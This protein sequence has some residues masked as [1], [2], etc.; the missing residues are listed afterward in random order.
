[1][2]M[3]HSLVTFLLSLVF[4]MSTTS[5]K[6][7]GPI[8]PNEEFVSTSSYFDDSNRSKTSTL[9]VG[10]AS[11]LSLVESSGLTTIENEKVRIVLNENGSIR[12]YVNKESKL[13]FT[14]DSVDST[15]I[16]V[17]L[18]SQSGLVH[19]SYTKEVISN[20]ADKKE[21]KYTYVFNG[22][23][24]VDTFISLNKNS[25][26]VT[27][28]LKLR[29]CTYK[30]DMSVLDVEYP[31]IQNIRTLEEKQNDIF[32]SPYATGFMFLDPT[33]NFNG[34]K[35][36]GIGKSMGTYP[37]G[38]YYTMQFATYY[39]KNLGGFY[40]ATKDTGDFIKSFTFVGTGDDTCRMSIYHYVD[41]LADEETDFDYDIIISNMKEG[42][43]EEGAKKYRSWA[44]D[45]HW[46]SQGALKNRSD[47]NKDL[48]EN[49]SLSLFGFRS[50]VSTWHDMVTTYDQIT[51]R[52]TNKILNIAIYQ[53][54]NYFDVVREYGH[55][56]SVFEFNSIS[57]LLQFNDNA[58]QNSSLYNTHFDVNGT[59][60][61]YQCPYN[62]EWLQNR[63]DTE[64]GYV[65]TYDV[66]AFYYDVA[67]TAIHPIQCFNDKHNHGT[68]INILPG[69][70]H[71]LDTADK[72]AEA[73][74]FYS[75][76]TEMLHER[77]LPYIDFYQ[78]RANGG[79]LGWMESDEIRRYLEDFTAVKIPMFDYVYHEYGAV[80]MDGYLVPDDQLGD[81]YYYIAAY[82]ALNGGICEYNYEYFWPLSSLPS[83]ANINIEM[84]D[85]IERLGLTR[86]TFG[87][88]YIVYGQM[89]DAPNIGTGMSEYEFFNPN[90]EPWKQNTTGV[91]TLEGINKVEDVVTSAY[92]SGDNVALFFS[93]TTQSPI[94]QGFVLQALRDYGIAS[95]DLYLTSTLNG[96]RRHVASFVNGK[97]NVGLNLQ[98]HQ[99]YMLEIVPSN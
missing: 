48:F 79:L 76:G 95:G 33:T 26:E 27:F 58:I 47:Y 96:E 86:T 14:K 12:E 42:R 59:P 54:K 22:N 32:A 85:Y 3:K 24:E 93:N 38:W 92:R 88:D 97:V 5:C 53:N 19:N 16:R 49:T 91:T 21:V 46:V 43:W 61:Y 77:I 25:D 51:S 89:M 67:F 10:G 71:Q 65:E 90:Y 7:N 44:K 64:Q 63:V 28:R 41:D 78:A 99:V 81:S 2:K 68:K 87:K 55:Q 30:Q 4:I 8:D 15:P 40:W 52:L 57:P 34:E 94:V 11:I 1:M 50:D 45:Q 6:P 17:D 74:G 35:G 56:Y 69:F 13:Y 72:Q 98:P 80:R 73:N 62:E 83:A 29:G 84:V 37:T 66:D 20:T 23:C 70:Y 9:D 18:V 36:L 82:T 39:S 31:I 60:F 75:V